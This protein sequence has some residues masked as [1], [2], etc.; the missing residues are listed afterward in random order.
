[1]GSFLKIIEI[2][3]KCSCGK[4]G[5]G[6]TEEAVVNFMKLEGNKYQLYTS[7]DICGEEYATCIFVDPQVL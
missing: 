6:M 5:C 2:R 4:C 1:M 7:L 3:E